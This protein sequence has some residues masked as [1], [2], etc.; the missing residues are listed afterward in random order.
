MV[1]KNPRHER[2]SQE[3]ATGKSADGRAAAAARAPAV[4]VG[5][6]LR[7]R[8]FTR[9]RLRLRKGESSHARYAERYRCR[10]HTQQRLSTYPC[11]PAIDPGI[12]RSG[13]VCPK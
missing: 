10:R 9:P 11:R 3:L 4:E 5:I 7:Y 1:L 2:F 13:N 8:R 12:R 6:V